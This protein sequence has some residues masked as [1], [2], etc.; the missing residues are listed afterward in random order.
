LRIPY[1]L[2]RLPRDPGVR[3]VEVGGEPLRLNSE[4]VPADAMPLTTGD[5]AA[6]VAAAIAW[7]EA[8]CGDY[9][10]LRRQFVAAYFRFIAAEIEAHRGE[11][12]ERLKPYDELFAPEDFLW[13]AL[14][15]LPRGWVPV[16]DR[17][18]PADVVFWDGERAIAIELGARE[19][20]RQK[21]LLACGV[22]VRRIEPGLF[23]RLGDAVPANFVD[24]WKC[25]RL[26]SSPFRRPIP[27]PPRWGGEGHGEVGVR[28]G[29]E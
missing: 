14:R 22:D 8:Q 24:F 27:S 17:W 18:L 15:P 28:S 21:A 13:S 11:L 9:A 19:T 5:H 10:P 25:Q 2:D 16:G 29:A 3:S 6:R 12:A 23:G 26:P 1:G 20:D 4:P 7:L